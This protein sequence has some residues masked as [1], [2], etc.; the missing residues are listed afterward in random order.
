MLVA[1][2]A[3]AVTACLK[4]RSIGW[5]FWVPLIAAEILG[6]VGCVLLAMWV[7]SRKGE[8]SGSDE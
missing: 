4:D 5:T 2:I 6:C 8:R 3:Y 1:G 7:D